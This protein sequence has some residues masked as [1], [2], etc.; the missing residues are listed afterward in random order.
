MRD[1]KSHLLA[2]LLDLS[3]DG[4]EH[5]FSR[6]DLADVTIQQE[7]LY[8]HKIMRINY[9]TYDTH[10]DQ[11]TV[12]TRTHPDFMVLAHE[13][14]E[15]SSAHP[16]WY[17]RVL[18]I[19]HAEVR[20]VGPRSKTEGRPQRMEFLWVRWFGRDMTRPGGWKYKRPHRIG[21]LDA[22][23]PDSGAFGFVDPAAIIRA[24]HIIP[25][26]HYGRTKEL[27]GRSVARHFDAEDDE[28]YAF[29]YVNEYVSDPSLRNGKLLIV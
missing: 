11:D 29:Y 2:R 19:F 8:T 16:Y 28:D 4:D 15:E 12:N 22:T 10:R 21:F 26:F 7:R 14:E 6:Q 27:L 24:A 20:H 1:L 17:G 23:D 18:G 9:T 25:A 5:Q 3:Y 13:E